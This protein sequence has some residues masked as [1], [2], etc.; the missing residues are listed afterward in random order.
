M[1]I[2]SRAC[3]NNESAYSAFNLKTVYDV[4]N[5]NKIVDSNFVFD[6]PGMI[7]KVAQSNPILSIPVP[8]VHH[9]VDK[10]Q[11]S[12]LLK[13]PQKT[14]RSEKQPKAQAK[15]SNTTIVKLG[16]L[17]TVD[18]IKEQVD[19]YLNFVAKSIEKDLGKCRPAYEAINATVSLF[20]DKTVA[21]VASF[22]WILQFVP[23]TFILIII[24]ILILEKVNSSTGISRMK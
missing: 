5:I 21:P 18:E 16:I 1:C 15:S 4:S 23:P 19:T 2:F 14:K 11:M 24:T 9:L 20:C 22:W 6:L 17:E 13:F 10:L 7:T 3:K 12:D 8:L